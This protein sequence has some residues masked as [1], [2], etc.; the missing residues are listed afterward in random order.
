MS[1]DLAYFLGETVFAP[2]E[3]ALSAV[4][5]NSAFKTGLLVAALTAG[6]YW[7]LKPSSAFDKQGNAR[8]WILLDSE[9][10]GPEPTTMP[11]YLGSA[12]TGYAV[13][14]II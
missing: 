9:K 3:G 8:P 7:G 4:G 6:V 10:S 2:I 1:Q 11:W 14:L 12:L 13:N 5:V